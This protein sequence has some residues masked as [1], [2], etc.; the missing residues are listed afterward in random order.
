MFFHALLFWN[1]VLF[2][3]EPTTNQYTGLQVWKTFT[4][5]QSKTS[6]NMNKYPCREY[7]SLLQLWEKMSGDQENMV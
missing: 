4:F 3:V 6:M 5:S 1:F 2:L 7:F